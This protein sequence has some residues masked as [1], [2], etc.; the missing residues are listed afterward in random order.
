[1]HFFNLPIVVFFHWSTDHESSIHLPGKAR[2]LK[3]AYVPDQR[4]VSRSLVGTD[5]NN[6]SLEGFKR[7]CCCNG[8]RQ[9]VPLSDCSR[10]KALLDQ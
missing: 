8:R 6:T 9:V 2:P 4:S 5:S 7:G 1:M 10:Y 3:E